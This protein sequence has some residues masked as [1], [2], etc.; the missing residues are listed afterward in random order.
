MQHGSTCFARRHPYPE[1]EWA[2][3]APDRSGLQAPVAKLSRWWPF[4]EA[5]LA[6]VQQRISLVLIRY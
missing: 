2:Q 3:R 5:I 6:L 1:P 4:G